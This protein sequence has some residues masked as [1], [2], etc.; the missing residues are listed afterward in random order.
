MLLTNKDKVM[1][2]VNAI[3]FVFMVGVNFLAN[4]LPINNTTTGDLSDLYPNLFVP[5]G[6]TFSIWGVIY[7][8]LTG[9]I[10]YSFGLF[11]EVKSFEKIRS[12]SKLFVI[13][14]IANL[15]WIF[16][17]HYKLVGVSIIFMIVILVSMIMINEKTKKME[18]SGKEKLFIRLPFSL[19]FGWITIATIANV[20][21]LLV[22][23]K[24]DGFGISEVVWTS[25]VLLIGI[26][27]GGITTI[28][29]KDIAYGLV[30][31]WA[32][33]G[34]LIK[35]LSVEG[36]NRQYPLIINT[37]IFSLLVI[38]CGIAYVI[39]TKRR[40]REESMNGS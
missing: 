22:S 20:T 31:V 32:Y 13:S 9:F 29:N 14:S 21:T 33:L 17:W 39:F 26:S 1:K 35:H 7:L 16:V 23:I 38:V 4:A 37:V 24:W 19:Y 28:K 5:V 3:V 30:I 2:I 18:L 34:I 10:L 11:G 6:L 12:V 25:I 27:I 36:F 8:L 40:R 15:L